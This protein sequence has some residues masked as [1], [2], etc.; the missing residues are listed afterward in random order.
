MR[1]AV[2]SPGYASRRLPSAMV[3]MFLAFAFLVAACGGGNQSSGSA[4]HYNIAFLAAASDNGFNKAAYQGAVDV[5]AKN[6]ASVQIFDGKF[7]GT[8]Q[9]NQMQDLV[10]S[11]RF[12]AFIILA[13]DGVSIASVVK[14]AIGKGMKVAAANNPIGPDLVTLQPQVQ[15]ITTTVGSEQH[16]SSTK[17]AEFAVKLCGSKNPCRVVLFSGNLQFPFDRIRL[18]AWKAVFSQ[19]SNIQ[20]VA[21]VEG[22]YDRQKS[23]TVMQDVLQAHPNVDLV[24]SAADQHIFG[25]E[26]ALTQAGKKVDAT[27]ANG[28]ML[29]GRGAATDSVTKV[30]AGLWAGTYVD[31]PYTDGKLAAEQLFKDL[32]GESGIQRAIDVD[33]FSPVGAIATQ[34]SLQ[35]DPSFKG[36]WTG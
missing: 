17:Q 23:L 35:K 6:N 14:D 20:M 19:H 28:V 13:N 3:V 22:G 15:G 31:L 16:A 11:K 7:D 4:K 18:E 2:A 33:Q 25:A 24:I 34:T 10:A 26:L 9:F 8:V 27:G 5:A 32:R 1:G 12:D 36:E 30:K 29:L 21:S